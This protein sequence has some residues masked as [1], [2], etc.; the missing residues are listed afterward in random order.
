VGIWVAYGAPWCFL[1]LK[2]IGLEKES[3][4][5]EPRAAEA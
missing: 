2:L 1:K 5:K 4:G 3:G